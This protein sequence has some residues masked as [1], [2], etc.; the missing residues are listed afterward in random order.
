MNREVEEGKLLENSREITYEMQEGD[1][2]KEAIEAAYNDLKSY[3]SDKFF[4]NV[5]VEMSDGQYHWYRGSIYQSRFYNNQQFYDMATETI[6]Q[7]E[8]YNKP[9]AVP[10]AIGPAVQIVLVK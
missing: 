1:T 10:F 9:W 3:P 7:G 2:Y 5:A 8:G 6:E 4:I